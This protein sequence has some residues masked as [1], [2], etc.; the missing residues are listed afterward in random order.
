AA[1]DWTA[2][3]ELERPQ[4]LLERA[5]GGVE[6]DAG[7]HPRD[8]HAEL[9]RRPRLTLPLDADP[10]EEIRARRG[11]LGQALVA[12]RP[13]VAGARGA[14]ERRRPRVGRLDPGNE[15]ASPGRAAVGDRAL[16]A[17]APALGDRL[18]GE[19]DDGIAAGERG[20]RG[21][22]GERV[23]ALGRYAERGGG[24][25]GVAREDGDAVAPGLEPLD[26]RAAEKAGRAAD[27]DVHV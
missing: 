13:V 19:V 16:G 6:H 18:A 23:P 12:A 5:A 11:V 24:L 3:A 15:V 14:D 26:E 1:G 9:A 22:P 21:R 2:D 7:A 25:R 4:H 10:G 17:L 8:A 20:G 27:R